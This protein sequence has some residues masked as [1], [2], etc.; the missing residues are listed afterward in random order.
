MM[1]VSFLLWYMPHFYG[2]VQNCGNNSALAMELLKSGT[3]LSICI[4]LIFRNLYTSPVPAFLNDGEEC[5]AILPVSRFQ[6]RASLSHLTATNQGALRL[7]DANT[8]TIPTEQAC[9]FK[10]LTLFENKSKKKQNSRHCELIAFDEIHTF[11][12]YSHFKAIF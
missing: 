1:R 3:K 12:A 8:T 10:I 6:R 4:V 7:S 11:P 2:L 5:S 9:P